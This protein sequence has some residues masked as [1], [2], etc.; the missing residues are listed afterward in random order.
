MHTAQVLKGQKDMSKNTFN[1]HYNVGG[2]FPRENF[3]KEK[4]YTYFLFFDSIMVRI[5]LE[6]L[7]TCFGTCL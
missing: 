1:N 5:S 4:L 2:E 3:I 6:A 7:Y